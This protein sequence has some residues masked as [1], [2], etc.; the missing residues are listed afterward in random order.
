MVHQFESVVK[1]DEEMHEFSFRYVSTPE[2]LADEL[3]SDKIITEVSLYYCSLKTLKNDFP[4]LLSCP[5]DSLVLLV[6]IRSEKLSFD[7]TSAKR[8][9]SAIAI[10]TILDALP[11]TPAMVAVRLNPFDGEH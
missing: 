8:R 9:I 6:L 4:L 2:D 5:S 3:S 10:E 1:D 7:F 11:I